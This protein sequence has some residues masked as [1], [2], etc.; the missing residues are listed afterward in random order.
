MKLGGFFDVAQTSKQLK[1]I[2]VEIESRPDFW[3]N[4]S[5]SAPILKKKSLLENNLSRAQKLQQS[6]DDLTVALELAAEGEDDYLTEAESLISF[7]EAELAQLEIQSL[8]G[9]DMDG[10]DALVTLNAGAGGTE[11]CDWASMLFRMYLRFGERKGWTS[12]IFDIQE[13]DE[14]GIKSATFQIS[15]QFAFGLLKAESG[16]H[17]LVRI[18]PFDSNARRHTSFASVFVTPVLDDTIEI[19]INEADLRI[20]TYR[21]SGAGGQHINKTDSAVR[22]THA[23]TGIVV[24]CQTQRSQ[25]QNRDRCM[26]LLKSKLFE[27]EMEERR[28]SQE[29]AEGSKSDIAW[30]SQIRSYVLHPY[31]LVKDHRTNLESHSPDDVLDGSLDNF[32]SEYLSKSYE[33]AHS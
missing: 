22:I 5:V 24:Q 15:G 18:S 12:E 8:L 4:P 2:E 10:N 14:A 32:I 7:L 9:G 29:A 16:V 30:G 6:R 28:K 19:E 26:K 11:S 1:D 23:P 17:R 25:H 13:G 27:R 20:D 3:S 33:A 21:A 31:K